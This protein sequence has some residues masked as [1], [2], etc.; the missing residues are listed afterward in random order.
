M[1]PFVLGVYGVVLHM[2]SENSAAARLLRHS[3]VDRAT[4]VTRHTSHVVSRG[5]SA[6]TIIAYTVQSTE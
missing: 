4:A 3:T 5:V 2:Y 1:L 6:V